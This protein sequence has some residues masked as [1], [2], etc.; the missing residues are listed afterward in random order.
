MTVGDYESPRIVD[1]RRH[2]GWSKLAGSTRREPDQLTRTE[3]DALSASDRA[4]YDLERSDWHA[5]LPFV[6]T[7]QAAGILA[8]MNDLLVT[9][10]QSADDVKQAILLDG[11]AGQGKSAILKTFLYDRYRQYAGLH[12]A[13]PVR[14][15]RRID[16]VHVSMRSATNELGCATRIRDFF[17]LPPRGRTEREITNQVIDAVYECGVKVFAIDELHFMGRSRIAGSRMSNYL[18]DLLNTTP[19]TFFFAG[20]NVRDSEVFTT[21]GGMDPAAEQFLSLMQVHE[22]RSFLADDESDEWVKTLMSLEQNLRLLDQQRGDLFWHCADIVWAMTA[23]R[24]RSLAFLINS[25]CS[26]AIRTGT[27]R[28]TPE[29]IGSLKIDALAEPTARKYLPT[30]GTGA[31]TTR[32]KG[33]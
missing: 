16:V 7:S 1:H 15:S 21:P 11:R 9:N 4:N 10:R 2:S 28:L 19:C 12:A 8:A 6:H 33:A 24:W 5:K 30:L 22:M 25:A 13:E 32:P 20:N 18:K 27:E 29:L 31:W 17:E 14:G 26:K 23:G 3:Y